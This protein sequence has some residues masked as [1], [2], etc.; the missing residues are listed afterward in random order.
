[1]NKDQ[2]DVFRM[3]QSVHEVLK[4]NNS[5]WS[6][7]IPF[8]NAVNTLKTYI[9]EL[10]D[11][12]QRQLEDVS[13]IA[14]DK[15][16]KRMQMEELAFQI[17]AIV[18]FYASTTAN[19]KLLAKVDFN[20]SD[21]TLARSNEVAGICEQVHD[22]A[23]SN[24]AAL[25]PF[26]LTAAMLNSFRTS[27]DEFISIIDEPKATR[28][29]AARATK[30]IPGKIRRT[31]KL[32]KEQLDSGMELY[33]ESHTDF[34]SKYLK[35]RKIVN[36]ARRRRALKATFVTAS[37]GNVRVQIDGNIKRMT[38]GKSSVYVQHL[39]EGKH[40][41]EA[42]GADGGTKKVEFNLVKGETVKLIVKL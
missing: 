20:R 24:A 29:R 2:E 33:R 32:L 26:G 18:V 8:G 37:T 39:D 40:T 1:M 14:A 42:T 31:T 11:L 17:Q 22:A 21:Y 25:L 36:T 12:R 38:K 10:S 35:A 30:K 34:Y 19:I 7:I 23:A 6:A 9:D 3:Y 15:K 28:S 16:T 4:S 13:G 5:I 41:L 27:I